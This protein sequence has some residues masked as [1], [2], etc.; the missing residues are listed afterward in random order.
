MREQP[1][2]EGGELEL[3]WFHGVDRHHRH[4]DDHGRGDHL[5]RRPESSVGCPGRRLGRHQEGRQGRN[6]PHL[7]PRVLGG[8]GCDVGYRNRFPGQDGH[9]RGDDHRSHHHPHH[10]H[11]SER[12]GHSS[13]HQGTAST[14]TGG[15]TS[16]TTTGGSGSE[17]KK[18]VTSQ[19]LAVDQA[20]IDTAQANLSAAQQALDDVNLVSTIAGTVASVSIAPADTVTAGGS[21][22]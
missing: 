3:V 7:C 19:Q 17:T 2:L 15:G 12:D 20:A 13:S 14:T 11:H 16:S 8:L 4:H 18:T 22:S 5:C 1:I 9:H 10:H 6:R 21:S